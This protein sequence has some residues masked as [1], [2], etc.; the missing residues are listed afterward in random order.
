[1][2][3]DYV[4]YR[5]H[6]LVISTGSGVVTWEEIKARQDQT[7]TDP[8]FN[9]EYDQIVD[10]R[11]VTDFQMSTEQTRLL[12]HRPIFSSKSK[13]AFIATTPN[14][15]GVGR[16]WETFTESS[17]NPSQIRVFYEA[18][19]ALRWLGV[20]PSLLPSVGE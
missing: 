3:F 10:L 6:C 2:P 7:Q 1:M 13:R 4:V 15:F 16:M 19:S 11:S 8:D 14:I 5:E 18:A 12:A 20:D 9:P 17:V